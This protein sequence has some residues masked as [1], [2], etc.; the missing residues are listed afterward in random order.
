VAATRDV[1]GLIQLLLRVT[2]IPL[3]Q[4]KTETISRCFLFLRRGLAPSNVERIGVLRAMVVRF[5]GFAHRSAIEVDLGSRPFF[6]EYNSHWAGQIPHR[7]RGT[8]PSPLTSF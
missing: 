1:A 3:R 5:F 4:D 7:A 8:P 2:S 6:S